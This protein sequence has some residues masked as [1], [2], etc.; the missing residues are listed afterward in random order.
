V[1]FDTLWGLAFPY[2]HYEIGIPSVFLSRKP[3]MNARYNNAG[4]DALDVTVGAPLSW[5]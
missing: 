3:Q 1:V 5:S 2:L 4:Y